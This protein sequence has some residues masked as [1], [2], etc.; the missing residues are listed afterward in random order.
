MRTVA[1]VW[2]VNLAG[3]LPADAGGVGR[4]MSD[5]GGVMLNVVSV[6]GLRPGP[7]IGAYNV[8]KAALLPT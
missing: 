4:L 1:K 8:G 2:D 5:H 7:F 6:G 3:P